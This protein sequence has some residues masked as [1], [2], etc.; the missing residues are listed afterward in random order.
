MGTRI[1]VMTHK[2]FHPPEDPVYQPLHVGRAR[3]ADLGFLGDDTGDNISAK[4]N[5]YGELTGFYWIWKNSDFRGNVGVC[6]YRRYFISEDMVPLTEADF[7]RILE[8]KDVITTQAMETPYPYREYYN[9]AHDPSELVLLREAVEKLFPEDLAVFD[10]TMEERYYYF[11]NL[12]VMKREE[13]D[14]YCAWLFAL[15]A[16][17][18]ERIDLTGYDEYHGRVYG[19]LSEQLLRTW[20]KKRGLS[21]YE[22]MAGIAG[23]KAETTEFKL[24]MKQLFRQGNLKE[25]DQ[26]FQEILKVRPDIAQESADLSGEIP[27]IEKLIYLALYEEEH[28]IKG[29]MTVSSDL[30]EL[31]AH[32]RRTVSIVLNPSPDAAERAYLKEKNVS[33]AM[34][35][36]IR[37]NEMT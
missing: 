6:H 2:P 28:H 35:E 18:E 37:R 8:E 10:D 26:L 22:C 12:C 32:Y 34:K 25:A 31:I 17:V 19:F 16:Y 30:P 14:A 33:E 27:V 13:F 29:L 23:E 20:T 1:Y 21:V 24:A 9:E 5:R 7:D 4:N 3:A 11:G 15:M 36:F